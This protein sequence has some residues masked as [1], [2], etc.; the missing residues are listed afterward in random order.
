MGEQVAH[1]VFTPDGKR[2]IAAKFPGHKVA[3]LDVDGQKVT[4]DKRDV[5]VGCG[6]TT[7]TSPRTA[8]WC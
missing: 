4:Y 2:A 7:S 6:R 5:S 3:L 1:V 8:S